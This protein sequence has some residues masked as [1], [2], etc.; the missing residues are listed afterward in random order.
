M[1]STLWQGV[2]V[3]PGMHTPEEIDEFV[4][5]CFEEMVRGPDK[6]ADAMSLINPQSNPQMWLW[7]L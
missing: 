5:S 1:N 7:L 2:L 6:C 3:D 4:G